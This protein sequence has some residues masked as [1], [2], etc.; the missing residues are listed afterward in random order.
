MTKSLFGIQELND[1]EPTQKYDVML[2][3]MKFEKSPNLVLLL[4]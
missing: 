2:F 3:I 1:M 4:S